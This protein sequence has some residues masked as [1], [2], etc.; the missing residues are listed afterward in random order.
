MFDK[1]YEPFVVVRRVEANGRT[2][3]RYG[4][5]YV[6][7]FKNKISF[8]TQLRGNHYRFYTVRQEFLTHV[9]HAITNQ[10]TQGM[11]THLL[12]MRTLHR[13]DRRE[14]D[15]LYKSGAKPPLEKSPFDAGLNC[16]PADGVIL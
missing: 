4:E 8:I 3:P 7:R 14:L 13:Q 9:P 5:Q 11:Q 6:G 16:I 2:L 12:N 10:T 15:V 1:Y